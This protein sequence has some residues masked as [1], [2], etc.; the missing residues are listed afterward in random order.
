MQLV[1]NNFIDPANR[2]KLV[3]NLK[4]AIPFLEKIVIE[5]KETTIRQTKKY[6]VEMVFRTNKSKLDTS[7]IEAAVIQRDK[8]IDK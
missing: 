1:F 4:F 3:K 2:I 7:N 6:Q 5:K 8:D